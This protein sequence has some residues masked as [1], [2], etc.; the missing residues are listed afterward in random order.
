MH[1]MLIV[2][3]VSAMG[4]Q[5]IT[6]SSDGIL[7]NLWKVVVGVAGTRAEGF[8]GEEIMFKMATLSSKGKLFPFLDEYPG[9]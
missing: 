8:A 4:R 7:G 3:G 1:E 5:I 2:R 6:R 9:L